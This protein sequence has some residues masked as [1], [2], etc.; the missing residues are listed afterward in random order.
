VFAGCGVSLAVCGAMA[1]W[2]AT[3][4][5]FPSLGPTGFLQFAAPG[6]ATNHPRRVL[7]GHAVAI[8]GGALALLVF[9]LWTAPSCLVTGVD[10]ARIGAASLALAATGGLMILLDVEHPPAGATT[11]IVALGLL[12]EPRDLGVI[13]AAVL[14]LTLVCAALRPLARP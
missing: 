13:M 14:V 11:L 5:L 7:G 4:W 2:T 3:P 1:L 6:A 8:A 12:H 10:A 9:D